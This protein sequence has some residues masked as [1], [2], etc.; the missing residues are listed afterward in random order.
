MP[1]EPPLS[2]QEKETAQ[3]R[4]ACIEKAPFK[5]YFEITWGK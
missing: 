1:I 4:E 2:S 5:M 3:G